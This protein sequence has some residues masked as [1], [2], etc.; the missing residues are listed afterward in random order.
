MFARIDLLLRRWG[1]QIAHARA[2]AV[3]VRELRRLDDR[4]LADIGIR[5]EAIVESVHAMIGPLAEPAPR[6]RRDAFDSDSA[7]RVGG[8]PTVYG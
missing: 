8:A 7:E 4:M 3:A 2:R 1:A 6:Q 5:R